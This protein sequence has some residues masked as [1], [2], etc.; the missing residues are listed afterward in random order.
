MRAARLPGGPSV[1]S[2][3][4]SA[5]PL[6]GLKPEEPSSRYAMIDLLDSAKVAIGTLTEAHGI[7]FGKNTYLGLLSHGESEAKRLLT[8]ALRWRQCALTL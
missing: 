2:T 3:V 7:P 6:Q 8:F 1:E 5:R 4:P